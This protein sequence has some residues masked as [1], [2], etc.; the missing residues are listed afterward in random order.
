MPEAR[1]D[2]DVVVANPLAV[3]AALL[4]VLRPGC[5]GVETAL[6]E[7]AKERNEYPL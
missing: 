1:A 5:I 2:A 3:E 6:E 7:Q 4:V